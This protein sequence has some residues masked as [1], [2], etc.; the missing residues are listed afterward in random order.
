MLSDS[1]LSAFFKSS[2]DDRDIDVVYRSFSRDVIT[3]QNPP[4]FLSSSGIRGG[5]FIS[6][7]S[8]TAQ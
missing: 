3:V 4:K 1:E 6:V 8:F 2:N 7:Y 5:I